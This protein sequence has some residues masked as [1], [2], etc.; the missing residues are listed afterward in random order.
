MYLLKYFSRLTVLISGLFLC[1]C[2][3]QPF[4]AELTFERGIR[5]LVNILMS[6]PLMTKKTSTFVLNP[7]IDVDS[8]QVMQVSLDIEEVFFQEFRQHYPA[9][10]ITRITQQNLKE[11]D[12]LINGIIKYEVPTPTQ[13]RKLYHIVASITDLRTHTVVSTG[14][15]WIDDKELN[16]TPTPS[17]ADNPMYSIQERMLKNFVE[18]VESSVGAKIGNNFY[19]FM[20]IK[21]LLVQA[22]TAY[23]GRQYEQARQLFQ[24]VTQ[25]PGGEVIEAYGGSY[26][27]NFRLGY[28]KEAETDFGKMIAIGVANNSI[29]IKLMFESNSTDFLNVAELKVQYAIWIKQIALYLQNHAS[30]CVQ[31]IGHTSR[32]GLYDYNLLLSKQRAKAIQDKLVALFPGIVERCHTVGKGSDETI[33][34]TVPDNAQNAVD[35]RVEFKIADCR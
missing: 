7:F 28:L 16:Y 5:Q 10:K 22:Q 35:R 6:Q 18:I 19:N 17:Y 1:A 31:I 27:A 25:L 29:P 12:Y 32:A 14:N 9:S 30:K 2:Q 26:A 4:V 15:V 23:N 8:G 33:V 3:L 11:A 34:G 13:V 20:E 21:S 24:M